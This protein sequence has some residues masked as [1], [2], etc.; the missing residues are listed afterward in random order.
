MATQMIRISVDTDDDFQDGRDLAELIEWL[1]ET[2]NAIPEEYRGL[3]RI[4]F[5]C[6]YESTEISC[7]VHYERMKTDA[8]IAAEAEKNRAEIV[9]LQAR[10]EASDR[11]TLVQLLAKYGHPA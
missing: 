11:A 1:Q 10:R 7:S 8:E 9:R 2:K 6:E 5:E 3:A 4:E